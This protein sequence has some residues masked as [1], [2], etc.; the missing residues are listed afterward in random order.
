[1]SSD[2]TDWLHRLRGGDSEALEQLVPLLYEEMRRVASQRLR[3][4]RAGHTLGATAL[5]HET[6]LRM[7]RQRRVDAKDREQFLAVAANTMRRIL[8]DHA[9]TRNRLK[10]GGA[11]SP[12]P[13]ENVID[14]L[15]D[16]EAE[17]MLAVHESLE[18]LASMHSRSA[19]VVELRFFG[20]LSLEETATVLGISSKTVQRDWHT[21]RAWL[22]KEVSSSLH[23]ETLE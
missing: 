2:V 13:L 11:E 8:V 9:R 20:G 22:R 5:V 14:F 23:S 6:Y 15:E 18:R 16:S 4:E 12:V 3:S 10:R 1:M 19:K 7:L 21:A 17:E